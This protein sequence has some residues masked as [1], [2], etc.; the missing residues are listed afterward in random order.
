MKSNSRVSPAVMISVIHE[1]A[2]HLAVTEGLEA[3]EVERVITE[4]EQ[5]GSTALAEGIAIPHAK[6]DTLE[7]LVG[8]VGRSRKGFEF[9]SEDGSPTHLV[10]VLIAPQNST[11]SHLKA[12]ARISRLFRSSSVRTRLMAAETAAEMYGIIAEEDATESR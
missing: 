3:N 10:F 8:M 11:G 12:L 5:L 9:G 2:A 1:L 4:R 7:H 6:L